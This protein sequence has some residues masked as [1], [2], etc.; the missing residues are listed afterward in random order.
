MPGVRLTKPWRTLDEATLRALPA[1]VGVFQ[2]GDAEGTVRRIGYAGG[3]SLFG[4]RS[5][6][7]GFVGQYPS[8]RV[9]IT[10]TYLTRFQEL[11]MVHA[12]D[13]GGALPPDQPDPGM[14]LGRLSPQ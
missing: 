6:L 7:A 4:L 13:H 12:H 1:V 3:R 14:R 5:E 9:E 8:F 10:S 11:L 2:L